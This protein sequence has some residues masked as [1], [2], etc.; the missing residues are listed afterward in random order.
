MS[1]DASQRHALLRHPLGWIACGF[2]SGMSP[3]APGTAGSLLALLPWFSLREL[4]LPWFAVAL[5]AAF[6]IG[7]V[8]C[9]WAVRRLKIADPSAVVWDE[10]VGQWIALTPLM[11]WPSS[12]LW[13]FAGFILFRIF[14]IAKPWPVSWADRKLSGGLGVMLDDVFAGIYAA[15]VLLLL[16]RLL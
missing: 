1:L 11:I 13:I 7:V 3:V 4:P 2:G 10:F 14:D 5:I 16:Q 15:L 12:W 8:A 9:G 6:A